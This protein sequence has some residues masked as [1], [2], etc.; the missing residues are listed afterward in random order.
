M[1]VE[2]ESLHGLSNGDG[3]QM[4]PA[5]PSDLK[6]FGMLECWNYVTVKDLGTIGKHVCTR[7]YVY[8]S[9]IFKC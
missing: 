6:L 2:I 8:Y 5:L 3:N 7:Y 1:P 9:C 4:I